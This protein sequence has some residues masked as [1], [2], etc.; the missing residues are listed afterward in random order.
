MWHSEAESSLTNRGNQVPSKMDKGYVQSVTENELLLMKWMDKCAVTMISTI[1]DTS[2]VSAPLRFRFT[3]H[4]H[5]FIQKP[6][7]VIEYNHNMG[8][9]NQSD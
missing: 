8:G 6:Q 5:E 1:H 7:C 3:D 4:G 9:V 2:L